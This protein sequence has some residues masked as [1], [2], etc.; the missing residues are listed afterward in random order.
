MPRL[1]SKEF[2]SYKLRKEEK[3]S[4]KSKI[5]IA[6]EGVETEAKYFNMIKNKNKDSISST[7]EVFPVDRLRK[8]GQ[9]HPFQVRDGLIEYYE[10]IIK[11]YFDK[12]I[13]SLWIVVDIDKHFEKGDKNS[14]AKCFFE[15]LSSLETKDKI[16]I[17]LAL[18]NPS[19][20]IWLIL[21]YK[22]TKEIDLKL[23]KENP[24]I[25]S[26][27]T[28]IKSILKETL[29]EDNQR[30]NMSTYYKYTNTAIKNSSSNDLGITNKELYEKVGTTVRNLLKS[31]I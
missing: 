15:F 14:S 7:V 6:Y 1:F 31:L 5:F 11:D 17:N 12:K 20:E 16:K 26:R 27:K 4:Y 18:S 23:I 13:D 24:K 21:H 2:N 3:I 19:F 28:Y 25:S 22:S 29:K 30:N 8:D 10:E 9:S